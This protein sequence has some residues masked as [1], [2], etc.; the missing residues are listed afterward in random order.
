MSHEHTDDLTSEEDEEFLR[1]AMRTEHDCANCGDKICYTVEIVVITVVV[2]SVENGEV[3]FA[4]A[5][6]DDGDFLYEPRF[7]EYECWE[8]V[9]DEVYSLLCDNPPIEE[10][11]SI[12]VCRICESG[13]CAGELCGLATKGEL[14]CSSR[15]PEGV[16]TTTFD[17]QD[18]KPDVICISCLNRLC[19]EYLDLWDSVEQGDECNEGVDIRC[20]RHGCPGKENC[21]LG[22]K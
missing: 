15:M 22:I 16:A 14:H 13:V 20:W 9:V 11:S 7:L 8:D 18:P 2:P 1:L 4:T 5:E 21:I 19:K 6:A 3:V 12:T 10:P 17:P